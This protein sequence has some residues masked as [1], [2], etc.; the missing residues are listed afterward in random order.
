VYDSQVGLAEVA[1]D[2]EAIAE[3]VQQIRARVHAAD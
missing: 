1:L 3:A 2:T